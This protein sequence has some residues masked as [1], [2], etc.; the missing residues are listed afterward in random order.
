MVT[1]RVGG[2]PEIYGPLSDT[3][4]VPG[5]A[6]ALAAAIK[7]AVE[8]PAGAAERARTLR[9]RIAALFT[10]DVMVD[11]VLGCYEQAL[12]VAPLLGHVVGA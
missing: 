12:S 10:L 1:T 8:D 9:A 5:D 3:L 7:G 2:I 11:S 6:K 4:V